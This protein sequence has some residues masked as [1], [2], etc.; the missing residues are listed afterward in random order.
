MGCGLLVAL[1]CLSL[2]LLLICS[3][4]ER[5][6]RPL[7]WKAA[8]RHA[9]VCSPA[10]LGLSADQ[11]SPAALLAVAIPQPPRAA[12]LRA[13]RGVGHPA[14][15]GVTQAHGDPVVLGIWTAHLTCQ[16]RARTSI[17]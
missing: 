7:T 12:H 14:A 3:I 13:R 5:Q 6:A 15:A 9:P 16:W 8:V 1:F 17:A 2:Y 10:A 4:T 11:L